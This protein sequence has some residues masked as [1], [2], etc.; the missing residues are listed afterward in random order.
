MALTPSSRMDGI[1]T[2]DFADALRRLQGL[3]GQ[4]MRVLIGFHGTFGGATMEG[5]LTR[6]RTL[7]PDHS[8]VS[9]MLDDR[10]SLLLDPIDTEVLLV[11]DARARR[12]WLEFHLPSGVV[13]TL[14]RAER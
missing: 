14:E 7:P 2:I 9:I 5:R 4:E 12:R 8:A 13:A 6:V 3:L 1:R 10:Q 11:D